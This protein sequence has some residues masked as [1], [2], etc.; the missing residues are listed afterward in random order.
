MLFYH[1]YRI[2]VFENQCF[3]LRIMTSDPS[4]FENFHYPKTR[5]LSLWSKIGRRVDQ[6]LQILFSPRYQNFSRITD[7][8]HDYYS[9]RDELEFYTAYAQYGIHENEQE[10]L[11]KAF[12]N[13][14]KIKKVLMIGC[15][16][17]RECYYLAKNYPQLDITGTDLNNEMITRARRS[18]RWSNLYFTSE[19]ASDMDD[20]FDLIWVTSILES[21]IQ[22]QSNRIKFFKEISDLCH[23]KSQVIMTP[24]I[25]TFHWRSH[26]FWGS[27]LLR[28]RWLGRE[29]WEKGDLLMANFGAHRKVDQ[30]V[31]SHFYPSQKDFCDELS[32]SGFSNMDFLEEQSCLI[33]KK[34]ADQPP[35]CV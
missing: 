3:N 33:K 14:P 4:F 1:F 34:G 10:A 26:Y 12:R 11:E 19:P 8:V 28:L 13:N 9:H 6:L 27:Q 22:G 31:Y 5:A 15:G 17:G 32:A 20:E 24:Q 29:Q 7:S 2:L 30:L 35:T 18:N 23:E 16:A 25:R 21:H